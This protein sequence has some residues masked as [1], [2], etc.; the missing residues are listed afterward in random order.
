MKMTKGMRLLAILLISG[1]FSFVSA[2]GTAAGTDIVNTATLS[3]GESEEELQSVDSNADSFKVDKKVDMT[4]TTLDLAPVQTKNGALK[5]ALKYSVT[6]TGNS[7][8]DFSLAALTT[9]NSAFDG[10]AVDNFNADNVVAVVDDNNDGTYQEADDQTTYIDELGID[11]T[12]VVFIVADIPEARVNGDVAVY[13]LQVQVSVGGNV[14]QKGDL[15]ASDD[16]DK[17]DNALT[18][19][20]VFADGAGTADSEKDGKFSSVSAFKVVIAEMSI[21]KKSIVMS[22][23]VNGTTNPKRIPGAVIRYCVTVANSGGKNVPVARIADQ[24][25][26]NQ[27]DMTTVSNNAIRIYSGE[28]E[29]DCAS[30]LESETQA[31]NG[32]VNSSTGAIIIDLAGVDAGKAKSAYFDLVIQ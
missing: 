16:S 18:V 3:F 13:D 27:F 25:N 1:F 26:P 4:V 5:V 2:D 12:A 30:V 21:A 29:F 14:G 20:I 7:I 9:S 11:E 32:T 8:Q 6:N 10:Q 19:Q 23:P 22:D 31:N 28:A 15:I 24:I 17:A